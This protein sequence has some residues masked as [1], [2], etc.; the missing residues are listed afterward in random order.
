MFGH[1]GISEI[2]G[3]IVVSFIVVYFVWM[4]IYEDK[5]TDPKNPPSIEPDYDYDEK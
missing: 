2:T 3:F 1:I 4:F 5:D